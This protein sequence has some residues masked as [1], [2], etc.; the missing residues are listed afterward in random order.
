MSRDLAAVEIEDQLVGDVLCDGS[1]EADGV[2]DGR[3]GGG[4][5]DQ[6]APDFPLVSHLQP[7]TPLPLNAA[8]SEQLLQRC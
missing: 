5:G 8:L 4:G 3:D 6:D 1:H 2:D 7:R